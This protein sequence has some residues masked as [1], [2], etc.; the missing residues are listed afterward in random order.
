MALT[1]Y[2]NGLSSFGI[3]V[4]GGANVPFNGTY[5]FVDA[6]RGSDGNRGLSP[7]NA[8]R[9]VYKAHSLMTDGNNDVCFVIG[10][11][12]SASTTAG[13]ARRNARSAWPIA[14]CPGAIAAPLLW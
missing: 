10:R 11:M 12:T 2:P 13:N 8:L 6:V 5:F 14:R 9:T 4:L 1:N 7:D 3:P